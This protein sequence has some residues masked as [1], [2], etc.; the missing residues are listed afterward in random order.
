MN[1]KDKVLSLL[2]LAARAGRL[3]SGSTPVENAVRSGNAC[4]VI[5]ARDASENTGKKFRDMCTYY[6]VPFF[7][8]KDRDALGHAVG[9][10]YRA[11]LAVT[12]EGFAEGI[13]K[14]L[15]VRENHA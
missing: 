6:Q 10:D 9:K 15:T 5:I 7:T 12:D 3:A 13:R 4:L 11:V 1:Q 8:Y 2:G 14:E